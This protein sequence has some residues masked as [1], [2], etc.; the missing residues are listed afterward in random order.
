LKQPKEVS[1]STTIGPDARLY[2]FRLASRIQK[3]EEKYGPLS[4]RQKRFLEGRL[5]K[6]LAKLNKQEESK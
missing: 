6:K 1:D 5:K 4:N 3:F 2:A